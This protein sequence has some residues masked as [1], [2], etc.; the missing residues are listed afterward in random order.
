MGVKVSGI[1]PWIRHSWIKKAAAPTDPN[2]CQAFHDPTNLLNL[3][4]Q[5]M[6]LQHAITQESS[7]PA[8][9]TSQKLIA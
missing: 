2:D 7:S 6:S 1:T 4:F 5:R 8:S 3:R 9:S